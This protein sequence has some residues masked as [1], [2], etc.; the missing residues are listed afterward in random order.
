[1]TD[2]IAISGAVADFADDIDRLSQAALMP[3]AVRQFA[4]DFI[5]HFEHRPLLNIVISDRGRVLMSW[6]ALY[7]DACH[8]P[9]D[10]NSGLTVNRFKAACAETGLCSPGRAAA[11]IDLMRFAGQIEPVAEVRRG[12]PLRLVPTAKMRAAFNSRMRNAF[13]AMALVLPEGE[14]GLA[15]ID[16][17]RF[18]KSFIRMAC[19]EFLLRERAIDYAPSI[20]PIYES[21]AGVLI[22]FSLLLSTDD[23]GLPLDK[24]M[25]ISISAL[26][27]AFSVSR[28]RIK[29]LLRRLLSEGL[30]LPGNSETSFYLSETLRRD[31]MR[32]IAGYWIVTAC[33]IRAGLASLKAE[34][35]ERH[36][37]TA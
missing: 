21:K 13:R 29:D 11:M 5:D 8:D 32:L 9:D 12:Y 10:P 2:R 28:P 33:G 31:I 15:N 3:V 34:P 25:T 20:P 26:S 7:F 6:M 24:P 35:V 17:L 1:M 27:R 23:D 14:A 22:V 19:D 36:H 30:L 18:E 37:Q 16:N 4:S